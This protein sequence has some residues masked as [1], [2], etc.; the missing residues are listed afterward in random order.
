MPELLNILMLTPY[1]PYP[2]ISGGRTRTYNLIKRLRR[3]ANITLVCF[4]R[5][6]EQ[7]FD[8]TPLRELCETHV[9]SRPSSPS[10]AKA[11]I[12][13]LTSVK[14]ITM[15]LYTTPE[16]RSTLASLMAERRFDVIHVESFYMLQNL[17]PDCTIPILLAEPA[18]E[19]LAWWRHAK[20]AQPLFQ[21]P[22]IALEALKMRV[23]EPQTWR[24]A[25]IVGAMSEIDAGIMQQAASGIKT[26]LAPNGVDEEYFQPNTAPREAANAIYMGDYKYFPNVD[27]VLYFAHEIMPL[28]RAVRSDFT[29]TLLGKDPPPDLIALGNLPNSGIRALGLVDDTRPYLTKAALFVCPLRSGSGTRFKLL[30]ALACALPVVS[31]TFG[32]EGLNAVHDEHMLLADTPQAFAEAVLRLLNDPADAAQLGTQGRQWVVSTH[33][34]GRSAALVLEAY[35]KLRKTAQ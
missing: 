32:A 18:I 6:E 28:I 7:S 15:R 1:L 5:P 31:T 34:W 23:F 11:A 29:L 14:P 22:A 9:I 21:R 26:M 24:Q 16:M 35:H 25:E 33:S 30:E 4:G 19:Y 8:L 3:D 27:A 2:P 10:T 12:L 20:V 13:S 17:P